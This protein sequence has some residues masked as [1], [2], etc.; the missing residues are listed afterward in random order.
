VASG[1]DESPCACGRALPRLGRVEGRRSD[2]LVAA[3]GRVIHG[4]VVSH[5]FR[6]DEAIWR[7]VREFQVVQ[8]RL[9][10]V[11]VSIVPAPGFTAAVREAIERGFRRLLG[12]G[13]A[14]EVQVLDSIPRPPSGK[15]RVVISCVADERFRAL[16]GAVGDP[17]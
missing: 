2:F 11:R 10:L 15:R 13:A 14:V 1:L 12:G 17:R 7:A 4:R 6:E 16:V 3:D 5:L 8:E 9:D